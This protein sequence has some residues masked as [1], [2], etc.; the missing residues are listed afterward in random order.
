MILSIPYS[1]KRKLCLKRMRSRQLI[2]YKSMVDQIL[3]VGHADFNGTVFTSIA[4]LTTA[5]YSI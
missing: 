5:Y 3:A 4:D 2:E 1:F